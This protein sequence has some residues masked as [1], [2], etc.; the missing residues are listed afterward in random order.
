MYRIN[1]RSQ[2]ISLLVNSVLSACLKAIG[3]TRTPIRAYNTF[4]II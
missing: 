2:L 1:I 3:L 4:P